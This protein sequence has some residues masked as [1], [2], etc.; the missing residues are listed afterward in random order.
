MRRQTSAPQPSP[1]K[2]MDLIR[3][4]KGRPFLVHQGRLLTITSRPVANTRRWAEGLCPYIQLASTRMKLQL[5]AVLC[6]GSSLL[7]KELTERLAYADA[8]AW[9][10]AR[11][12]QMCPL[13]LP[14]ATERRIRQWFEL[15]DGDGTG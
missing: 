14:E 12:R 7:Q 13:P 9:S 6:P 15:V 2:T 8:K 1:A 11:K 5:I 3:R 10:L 4:A